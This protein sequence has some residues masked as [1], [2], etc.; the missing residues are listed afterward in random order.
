[1]SEISITAIGAVT[2]V[3]MDAVTTCASIRAGLSRPAPLDGPAVLDL[4]D[5]KE[6]PVTGHPAGSLAR[7]FSNIGRWLQLAPP[8]LADLCSSGTLPTATD[9]PRFWARTMCVAVLPFLGERFEPDPNCTEEMIDQAFLAP[10][11]AR[12]GTFFKPSATSIHARG[13]VGVLESLTA[14]REWI[15]EGRADRVV[16]LVVDSLVDMPALEWLIDANRLKCDLNPVGLSPGEAACALMVEDTATA[17][18][19]GAEVAAQLRAVATAPEP[20]AFLKGEVSQGEALANVISTV[21]SEAKLAGAFAGPVV[22]DLNGEWWRSHELGTARARVP[23]SLWDGDR[24]ILPV[25]S[26]GDAGAAT[27]GLQIAVAC[28]ALARGYANGDSALIACSDEYGF[29]G[30]ALFTDR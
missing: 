10:L 3:G 5:Y 27:A 29:V 26:T 9:D 24:L 7:G 19:R 2:S 18:A 17:T 16:L 30:A 22:T 21:L 14:A 4:E 11:E 28:R 6:V 15:A 20:K 8:A 23:R 25:E 1:M 12:V 13:G